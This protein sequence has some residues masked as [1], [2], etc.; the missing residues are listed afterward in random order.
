MYQK[1][2]IRSESF[3]IS[4][5]SGQY[6]FQITAECPTL[7]E[8]GS[9]GSE[10]G[11]SYCRNGNPDAP[12]TATARCQGIS[13]T[14]QVSFSGG[15]LGGGLNCPDGQDSFINPILSVDP[16]LTENCILTSLLYNENIDLC[17]IDVT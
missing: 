7:F 10:E 4:N 11:I 15:I 8:I 14:F 5:A 6:I 2:S 9:E 1:P 3:F 12:F 16:A 13:G 17:N